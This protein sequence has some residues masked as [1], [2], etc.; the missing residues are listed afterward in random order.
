MYCDVRQKASGP[1]PLTKI[2]ASGPNANGGAMARIVQISDTHLSQ[3]KSHF[4][5]NWPPLLAW[6]TEQAPDL[7]VHTGDVTVNG[8]DVEDDMRVGAAYLAQLPAPYLVSPGNHDIGEAGNPYQPLNGSRLDRWKRH[9]GADRWHH[10]IEGWRLVGFNSMLLDTGEPEEADQFDWLEQTLRE[11]DGR[12]LALFTHRPLFVE[13]PDE[14]DTGYWSIKPV[15]RA[16]ILAM[17]ERHGVELVS[18]G[19]LHRTHDI[20]F[21]SCRYLWAPSTAFMVGAE[22]QPLHTGEL[23]LGAMVYD[24]NGRDISVR[25]CTVPGLT[26]HWIETVL[27]EVYPP[28]PSAA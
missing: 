13:T 23:R 7:I 27:D 19:H 16:R 10:D 4:A 5:G 3:G 6:V 15:P 22:M 2:V 21:G 24:I 11:A 8:A 12:R 26:S 9:F 17:I 1:V 14:P 28:P 25:H 18:A 20:R